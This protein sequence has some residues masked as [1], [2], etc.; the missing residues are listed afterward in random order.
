LLSGV[1]S[2]DSESEPELELE[3]PE[4]SSAS[5]PPAAVGVAFSDVGG[6]CFRVPVAVATI[7][8]MNEFNITSYVQTTRLIR[9]VSSLHARKIT[10]LPEVPSST[11]GLKTG[12]S[13]FQLGIG[14]QPMLDMVTRSAGKK[15][16][17]I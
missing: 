2:S 1:S 4:A 3:E 13:H 17:E 9:L 10:A 16:K 14:P 15:S 6:D 7:L 5:L 12:E 11:N 8:L